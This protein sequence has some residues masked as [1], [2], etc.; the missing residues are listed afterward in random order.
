MNVLRAPFV[1]IL[2]LASTSA[3]GKPPECNHQPETDGAQ[4]LHKCTL[5]ACQARG[6]TA[7]YCAPS[8]LIVE[9]HL[10]MFSASQGL[11]GI[12]QRRHR[13]RRL[14]LPETLPGRAENACWA[15]AQYMDIGADWSPQMQAGLPKWGGPTAWTLTERKYHTRAEHELTRIHSVSSSSQSHAAPVRTI[16]RMSSHTPLHGYHQENCQ[17]A[18]AGIK[19]AT[20]TTGAI[21]MTGN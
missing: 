2:P 11:K 15:D 18:P 21:N 20:N 17:L 3:K 10:R 1:F 14:P 8:R 12:L 4:V 5:L 13:A 19:E 6:N 9:A 16:S 7:A